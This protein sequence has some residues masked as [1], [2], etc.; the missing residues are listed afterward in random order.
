M[1]II[2]ANAQC[3]SLKSTHMREGVQNKNTKC[4]IDAHCHRH[5][6]K[7]PR[8]TK[9]CIEV[10]QVL[11][12]WVFIDFGKKFR[13][14]LRNVLIKTK[15]TQKLKTCRTSQSFVILES[16][17]QCRWQGCDRRH[18]SLF[19]LMSSKLTLFALFLIF[20]K[21]MSVFLYN[22]QKLSII[23]KNFFVK[24]YFSAGDIG[25]HSERVRERDELTR[26]L[27]YTVLACFNSVKHCFSI[28]Q[29][30]LTLFC[31]KT[32]KYNSFCRKM[33]NYDTFICENLDSVLIPFR[34]HSW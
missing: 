14:E 32:L 28:L 17:L 11:S 5:C 12:F 22:F 31:R 21:I 4:P 25:S 8:I 20:K 23:F 3:K 18:Y 10:L 9:D 19:S 15:K 13:R 24:S 1:F 27:Y 6:R 16:F 34:H 2:W 29:Q 26:L 33:L 7:D 30:C